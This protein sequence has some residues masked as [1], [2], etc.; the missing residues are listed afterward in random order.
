MDRAETGSPLN[1]EMAI[2][3]PLAL[4]MA[5]M[6]TVTFSGID[7]KDV[8]MQ[9]QISAAGIIFGPLWRVPYQ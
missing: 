3:S 9:V 4:G 1:S 7:G 2:D 6:R 8:D 5:R